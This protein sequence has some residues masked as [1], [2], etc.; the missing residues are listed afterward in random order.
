MRAPKNFGALLL[1]IL[2]LKSKNRKSK[3]TLRLHIVLNS[4]KK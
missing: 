3:I 2:N 1:S 4:K